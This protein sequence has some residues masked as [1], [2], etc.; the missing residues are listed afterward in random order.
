MSYFIN[1]LIYLYSFLIPG[2]IIAYFTFPRQ[3]PLF[4]LLFGMT[5]GILLMPLF[6][7]GVAIIFATTISTQLVLSVASIINIIGLFSIIKHK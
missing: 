7:F 4:N 2:Y 3:T 6:M 5:L 1:I